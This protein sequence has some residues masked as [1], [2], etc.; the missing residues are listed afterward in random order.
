M[1][2]NIDELLRIADAILSSCNGEEPF[3]HINDA[4]IL[5]DIASMI[6][7]EPY[8]Q[9]LEEPQIKEDNYPMLKV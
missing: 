2:S 7:L 5:R 1:K 9:I 6:H 8:E 3:I 4:F